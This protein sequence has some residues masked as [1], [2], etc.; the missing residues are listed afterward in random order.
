CTLSWTL[1]STL[2]TQPS[3]RPRDT[4]HCEPPHVTSRERSLWHT[5]RRS[6][7]SYSSRNLWLRSSSAARRFSS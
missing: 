1:S 2:C 6:S 4:E 5:T 3:L 7:A